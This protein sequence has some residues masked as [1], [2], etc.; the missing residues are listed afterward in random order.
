MGLPGRSARD[1][2]TRLRRGSSGTE[3]ACGE[4]S[5]YRAGAMPATKPLARGCG[6][7]GRG[8][9]SGAWLEDVRCAVR[10]SL[11]GGAKTGS[12]PPCES[13]GT[14]SA[15][16]PTIPTRPS[17]TS[18]IQTSCPQS[19]GFHEALYRAVDRL[20]RLRKFSCEPERVE[21]AFTF[22]DA[23][24]RPVCCRPEPSG[25]R[26]PAASGGSP[27]STPVPSPFRSTAGRSFSPTT[28]NA[29]PATRVCLKPHYRPRDRP[30]WHVREAGQVR[31]SLCSRRWSGP[32]VYSPLFGT[33]SHG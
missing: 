22:H 32:G 1:Q 21:H 6:P 28:T 25:S 15:P 11:T 26:S 2:G 8:A 5:P 31:A 18:T 13:S 7:E 12:W 20:Y 19:C 14:R 16:V 23:D 24:A 10:V 30:Y 29:L 9:G 3:A 17:P 27:S 33:S 4:H